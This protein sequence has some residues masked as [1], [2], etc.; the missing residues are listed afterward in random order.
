MAADEHSLAVARGRDSSLYPAKLGVFPNPRPSPG[1]ALGDRPGGRVRAPSLAG[2]ADN[3]AYT[4]RVGYAHPTL[5]VRLRPTPDRRL[6]R[7]GPRR[8][9]TNFEDK[10]AYTGR[11]GCAHPT[12]APGAAWTSPRAAGRRVRN[13]QLRTMAQLPLAW[14]TPTRRLRQ[15]PA[16]T[17]A[18]GVALSDPKSAG[19]RQTAAPAAQGAALRLHHVHDGLR[20]PRGPRAL[21]TPSLR[22]Y[23]NFAT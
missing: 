11:S 1:Q 14:A 2:I 23:G 17:R 7:R 12:D 15:A 13:P 21:L 19:R 20:Q 9:K 16:R 22:R 3:G 5:A 6:I 10:G 4:D 8:P 18:K